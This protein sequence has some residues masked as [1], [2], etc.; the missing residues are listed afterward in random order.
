MLPVWIYDD[1]KCPLA[2][3]TDLRAAFDVRT[4][5]LSNLGRLKRSW[6]IEPSLIGPASI[7]DLVQEA[8]PRA[9]V[10]AALPSAPVLA[11][12]GR[13]VGPFDD[14]VRELHAGSALVER[15]TGALL[16]A[17]V[18]GGD[19]PRVMSGDLSGLTLREHHTAERQLLERP[20]H[21]R[22]VRDFAI[23]LDLQLLTGSHGTKR[24]PAIRIDPTSTVHSTAVLDAEHGTIVIDAHA[25]IR[26]QS[27][28]IGPAYVGPHSTVV[29]RAV[30]RPNTAIGPWCKV[31]GEVGGV[32]FQG[33]ANKSHDGYLGDSWVGEWV[34]LGAGTTNSNLLNTYGEIVARATPDGRNER[35]GEQFLGAVIGDHVKTA[36]CTRIMTGC[37]IHTGTMWAATAPI[38]GSLAPFTWGTD[39][40]RRQFRL[41]KFLEVARAMMARR[42]VTPSPA[43]E[44]RLAALHAE[45]SQYFS[46]PDA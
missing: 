25:V 36:I 30:I 9:H 39:E 6:G 28:I 45:A 29:E 20:W 4:G 10:N 44:A 24:A 5:A 16:A 22:T 37:V 34:N 26:P 18:P 17:A 32:I 7:R 12:N 43:Y 35:T 46:T 19:L 21:F 38:S 14:S 40:S 27:V 8:H 31:G 15:G 11:V 41:S 13:W 42:S 1:G 33:Y 2:P 23:G 3:L